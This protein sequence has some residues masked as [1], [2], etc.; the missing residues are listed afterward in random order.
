MKT[1]DVSLGCL[2]EKKY[3]IKYRDGVNVAVT[4]AKTHCLLSD[5]LK[6]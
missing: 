2:F 3:H 5:V 4:E 1:D 6:T